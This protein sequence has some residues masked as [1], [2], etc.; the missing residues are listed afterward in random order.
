MKK[1]YVLL[2]AGSLIAG[3]NKFDDDINTN[4]NLPSQ[5]SGTQLIANACL[6]LGSLQESPQGEFNA[7]YLAET[8]Y[9][10]ASLYPD[11]G[12]SFYGIYQ[13]PLMNLQT[14]LNSA[15][16]LS[17]SEGPVNNQIA[18]AKILKA[19]YFWTIT[20]RWGDVPYSE[21]LMGEK[22]FTP[23]YDKQESIYDS[24]FKLLDEASAMIGSGVVSNDVIYNGDGTKWK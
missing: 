5:A 8:Q 21:A 12:T 11:G 18:I 20:D 19:Y 1:I 14:V 9:P 24:C 7:Q 17:G 4:P 16:S 2:F 15:S 3:C 22:D 23:K 10:G 6:S 13:G